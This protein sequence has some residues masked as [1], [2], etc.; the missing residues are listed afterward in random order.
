[1]GQT[2][3]P[4][5]GN[6]FTY[7]NFHQIN[8]PPPLSAP[9]VGQQ[10]QQQ[11]YFMKTSPSGYSPEYKKQFSPYHNTSPMPMNQ[12]SPQGTGSGYFPMS[13]G[14]FRNDDYS[15]NNGPA[16]ERGDVKYPMNWRSGNGQVD[17]MKKS[18]SHLMMSK[19]AM[20]Q[21]EAHHTSPINRN[22]PSDLDLKSI[23]RN[24]TS[25]E[26]D[27]IANMWISKQQAPPVFQFDTS[28]AKDNFTRSDS[29]LTSNTDDEISFDNM[30]LTT[31]KYGAIGIKN[32]QQMDNA[33][34]RQWS[35]LQ[36]VMGKRFDGNF[37]GEGASMKSG[38][39]F[40]AR[41]N[42]SS[43]GNGNRSQKLNYLNIPIGDM[44]VS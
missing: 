11:Q 43:N 17:K 27:G 39:G 32:S 36:S 8:R 9:P 13:R 10:Q 7:N 2:M 29:I 23:F 34:A 41:P 18:P 31:G 38:N 22:P 1:M 4:Q 3:T 37:N 15:N 30:S 40:S 19:N 24:K 33:R 42:F 20:P 25:D 12:Q 35:G 44:S 16:M 6:R 14:I 28:Q 5:M 26:I 21:N